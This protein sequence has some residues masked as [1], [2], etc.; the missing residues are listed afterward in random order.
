M[1]PVH[2]GRFSLAP[3]SWTE[4]VE[5]VRAEA[6][7]RG[8]SYLAL[9]PGVPTEPTEDAVAAQQQ[10]WPAL[11]WRTAAQAPIRPTVNGDPGQRVDMQTCSAGGR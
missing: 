9:V 1:I 11:P 8:Q 6:A 10:W 4:P 5:R 2:W 3:H 7:C